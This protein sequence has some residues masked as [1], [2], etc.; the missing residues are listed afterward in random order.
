M[1]GHLIQVCRLTMA[2]SREGPR[3]ECQDAPTAVETGVPRLRSSETAFISAHLVLGS[4]W[5]AQQPSPSRWH[6]IRR[7]PQFGDQSQNLGEQYSWHGD[8]GHLEGDIATVVNNLRANV[9][10]LLLQAGQGPVLDWL[11]RRQRAQEVAEIVGQRVE[12]ETHSIGS[13]R[14]A[15]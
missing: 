7:R 14:T 2:F 15:R 10:Q 6:W 8:L 9:D 12:L 3:L 1:T 11:G 13:E 5:N 4:F